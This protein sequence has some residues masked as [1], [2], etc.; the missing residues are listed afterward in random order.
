MAKESPYHIWDRRIK[1][2]AVIG[3]GPSGTPAA[4][5]LLEAG[6]DVQVFERQSSPGGIWNITSETSSLPSTPPPPSTSAF[7]PVA[8][9]RHGA[10][11]YVDAEGRDKKGFNPPNPAY[12]SLENNLPTQTM[13]VSMATSL[14]RPNRS[15]GRAYEW[16]ESR[17]MVLMRFS[18]VQRLP[19]SRQYTC[20]HQSHGHCF[21]RPFV[22]EALWGS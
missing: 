5:H 17:G 13:A 4:R 20:I 3:S 2:V 8:R 22:R 15:S 10:R 11:M 7:E 14:F 21:L 16:M 18:T 1:R 9:G 6:L 19:I 12:W